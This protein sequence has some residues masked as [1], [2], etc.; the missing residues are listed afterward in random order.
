M[1]VN[2]EQELTQWIENE[3][4]AL[5][6]LNAG[7]NQQL[8]KSVELVLFRRKLFDKEISSIISDHD[9]AQ[10]FAGLPITLDITTNLARSIT[11]LQLAPSR[12]DLGRLAHEWLKEG[13]NFKGYDDFVSAKLEGFYRR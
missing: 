13:N 3:K 11:K 5:E 10:K 8:Q 1:A 7:S 6:L 9:Y 2:Y 12:I 4:L